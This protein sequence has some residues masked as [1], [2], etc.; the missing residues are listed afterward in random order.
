MNFK[1]LFFGALASLNRCKQVKIKLEGGI[2]PQKATP[3]DAAY[4]VYVPKD[5]DIIIGRQII[6]LGF[7][8]EMPHGMA[9]FI[10]SRSGYSAKGIEA[11]VE[12]VD[13]LKEKIRIDAYIITGLIDSGYRKHLGAV[14][15]V[16]PVNF[17][18]KRLYIPKGTRIAQ[19]QFV[20]VPSTKMVEADKLDM[21][22]DRGGGFGH[23]NGK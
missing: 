23:T 11:M 5:F 12:R 20:S 21:T 4:D 7:A 13:G 22:D 6:D 9:A 18:Y 16:R 1:K 14:L 19:L 3:Y 17:W 10:R 8:L 2:M 15:Y